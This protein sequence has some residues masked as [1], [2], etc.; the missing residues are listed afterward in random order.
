MAVKVYLANES[1]IIKEGIKSILSTNPYFTFCCETNNLLN[2]VEMYHP[3]IIFVDANT[4]NCELC[5]ELVTVDRNKNKLFI[6]AFFQGDEILSDKFYYI[7]GLFKISVKK[8]ELFRGLLDMIRTGRYVHDPLKKILYNK[9]NEGND[10]KSKI[11]DL[12]KRE[13]EVLIQVANGL[14]NKEIA[15]TL[16][17]SERTVKNHLS[18]IFKKIEV[19]DRTQ[20]AVFAIKN[21]IVSL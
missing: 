1:D 12:T 8:D 21:E 14:F 18:S 15:N 20:A 5:K 9:N 10:D 2:G 3:N 4:K 6:V 11:N 13:M 16:N 7:N 17:I 19:S